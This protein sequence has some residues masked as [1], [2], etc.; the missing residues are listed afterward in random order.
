MEHLLYF[1][2]TLLLVH[3]RMN[4]NSKSTKWF[5]FL[6]NKYN[7][8]N[9]TNIFT[10]FLLELCTWT[11]SVHALVLKPWRGRL[12]WLPAISTFCHVFP[13]SLS[14]LNWCS[15]SPLGGPGPSPSKMVPLFTGS[16]HTPLPGSGTVTEK[17]LEC[18]FTRS[19]S[20]KKT[21]CISGQ[22]VFISV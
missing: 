21:D 4:A 15:L 3:P 7:K 6:N 12:P 10:H 14:G 13:L 19:R 1:L 17:Q 8:Y 20:A 18:D 11:H 2:N 22:N 9:V 16:M 5:I